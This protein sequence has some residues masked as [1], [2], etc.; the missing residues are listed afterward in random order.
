MLRTC[1]TRSICRINLRATSRGQR[2]DANRVTIEGVSFR[3]PGVF[4]TA[5][6]GVILILVALYGTWW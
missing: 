2:G 4:N 1:W 6:L 3:T 5:G